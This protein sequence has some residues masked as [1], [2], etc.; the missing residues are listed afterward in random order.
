MF[1]Y[2]HARHKIKNDTT[3]HAEETHIFV[4]S[5]TIYTKED[6]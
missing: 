2:R 3:E 5:K 4:Y 6:K 1:I